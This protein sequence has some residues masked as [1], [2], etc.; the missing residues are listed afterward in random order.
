MQVKYTSI[1]CE[2][3]LRLLLRVHNSANKKANFFKQFEGR[4]LFK[5]MLKRDTNG[6]SR[7]LLHF[8]VALNDKIFFSPTCIKYR[9][10]V[11]T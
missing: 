6:R 4:K 3:I 7:Y 5:I 11:N 1:K 2:V 9:N 10:S 8:P